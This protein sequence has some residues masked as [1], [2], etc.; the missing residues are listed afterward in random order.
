ME[1][2][3]HELDEAPD[4]PAVFR[5]SS[6]TTIRVIQKILELTVVRA[7]YLLV[8]VLFFFFFPPNPTKISRKAFISSNPFVKKS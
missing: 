6:V 4:H 7:Y 8:V 5:E 1:R 3:Q 2:H